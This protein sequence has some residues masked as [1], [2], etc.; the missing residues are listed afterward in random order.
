MNKFKINWFIQHP[1]QVGEMVV[2]AN[3]SM[4]AQ[5]MIKSMMGP[6]CIISSC[7]MVPR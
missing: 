3:C 6:N 2:Q 5:M 4:S 1:Y 7:V